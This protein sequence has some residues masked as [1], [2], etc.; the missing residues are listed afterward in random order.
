VQLEVEIADVSASFT[1]APTC[2][3]TLVASGA[4][5]AATCS[6]LTSGRFKW[7][8]RSTDSKSSSGSWAQY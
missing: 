1:G 5:A 4:T 7:Q 6:G 2:S 8:A 3:S